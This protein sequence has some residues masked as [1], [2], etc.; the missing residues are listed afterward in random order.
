MDRV[1]KAL[2]SCVQTV[3]LKALMAGDRPQAI[4]LEPLGVYDEILNHSNRNTHMF[5]SIFKSFAI[6][7]FVKKVLLIG[8]CLR[9]NGEV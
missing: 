3:R 8:Y 1:R 4:D 2:W 6:I 9:S 5:R 7:R